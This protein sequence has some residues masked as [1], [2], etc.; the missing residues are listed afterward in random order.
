MAYTSTSG[1]KSKM[2]LKLSSE[3]GIGREAIKTSSSRDLVESF[4]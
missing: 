2:S 4:F 1:W 3:L